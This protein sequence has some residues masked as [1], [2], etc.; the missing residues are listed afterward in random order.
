MQPVDADV[1]VVMV[2]AIT[3]VHR[4]IAVPVHDASNC[5]IPL[6]TQRLVE[7][8]RELDVHNRQGGTVL[9]VV[10]TV[11]RVYA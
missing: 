4:G 2:D 11:D 6:A 1:M 5:D 7:H 9:V 10:Y 3:I 8:E